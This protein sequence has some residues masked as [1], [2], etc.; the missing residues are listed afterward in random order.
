MGMQEIFM[1]KLFFMLLIMGFA[2]S[3]SADGDWT[4]VAKLKADGSKKEVAVNQQVSKVSFTCKQG[5]VTIHTLEVISE[6]KPMPYS[7]GA[8]LKKDDAQQVSV[9]NSINCSKLRIADE[10]QG[11][12]EVR[13]KK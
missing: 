5:E 12:Y 13:I 9:G 10:G 2:A 11:E 7:L 6:G 4:V 1:R 3:V 8:K